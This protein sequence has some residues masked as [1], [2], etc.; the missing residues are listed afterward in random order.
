M[1][2][3]DEQLKIIENKSKKVFVSAIAGS[4][5]TETIIQRIKHSNKMTL[6]LCFT[7]E[8]KNEI[9]K[10][11]KKNNIDVDKYQLKTIDSLYI[12]ILK[13]HWSILGIN[14]PCSLT[15]LNIE[16]NYEKIQMEKWKDILMKK[17]LIIDGNS[18][19]K[20]VL[21]NENGRM[22][23]PEFIKSFFENQYSEVII[24]EAQDLTKDDLYLL[25]NISTITNLSIFLFGDISQ[26]IYSWR[27]SNLEYFEE[28]I[29]EEKF[30]IINL[31]KN[32]RCKN[33]VN[34]IADN[35]RFSTNNLPSKD[36]LSSLFEKIKNTKTENFMSI[37][38]KFFEEEKYK[39]LENK[40]IM[41]IKNSINIDKQNPNETKIDKIFIDLV[42]YLELKDMTKNISKIS[43]RDSSIKSQIE[44]FIISKNF[45]ELYNFLFENSHYKENKIFHFIT[46]LR[47]KNFEEASKI[48]K[49]DIEFINEEISKY[50]NNDNKGAIT[51]SSCKGTQ[52]NNVILLF[53]IKQ[54]IYWYEKRSNKWVKLELLNNLYVAMTRSKNKL[55]FIY[56]E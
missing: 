36:E 32:W 46:L 44:T 48:I 6:I 31:S 10:R 29:E 1:K 21:F 4:G 9:N 19:H 7:N 34:E 28:L 17:R 53:D 3:S 16:I 52:F 23:N 51:I 33:D 50:H 35:F 42:N 27:G 25:Y 49:F 39:L 43:P 5:K 18:N 37:S 22:K 26:S 45:D 14:P 54:L 11:L 15:N 13:Y 30:E 24:D 56:E 41:I 40:E 12:T 47:N 8:V 20:K 38:S 55:L 2:I